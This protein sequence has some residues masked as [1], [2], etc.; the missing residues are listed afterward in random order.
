MLD[1]LTV[2]DFVEHVNANFPGRSWLGRGDRSGTDRSPDDRRGPSVGFARDQATAVFLD[3]PG[4]A[5]PVAPPAVCIRSSTPLWVRWPFFS[6]PSSLREIRR[7]CTIRP[8]S[9]EGFSRRLGRNP[10]P[11]GDHLVSTVGGHREV[12]TMAQPFLGEI[13]P[14]AF[15]FAPKGWAMCN[16]QLLSISQNTG[17]LLAAGND[18]WRRWNKQLRTARPARS[19]QCQ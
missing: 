9:T 12:I 18:L 7:D 13:T 2:S 4:P 11:S 6:C 1:Q 10:E 19:R 16:G 3:L 8:S 15:T 17:P 5:R 14:V